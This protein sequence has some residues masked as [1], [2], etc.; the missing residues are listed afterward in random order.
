MTGCFSWGYHESKED[1]VADPGLDAV[2]FDI[3]DTLFSTSEFAEVARRNAIRA[4]GRAGL[5]VPPEAA[6]RELKEVV[7]EFSSNYVKRM[8]FE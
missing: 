7:S 4:M 2:L 5:N 3:D 8:H 6:L 1:V